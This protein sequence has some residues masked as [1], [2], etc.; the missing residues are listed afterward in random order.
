MLAMP[1]TGARATR[2][3]AVEA[4]RR[5]RFPRDHGAHPGHRTEWWYVTGWLRCDGRE[6]GVQV[7]FFRSRTGHDPANPSRFA[8]H[9]LLLAHIAIA[10][11]GH[12]RLRHAQKAARAGFADIRIATDDT[13]LRLG[14]WTLRRTPDDAYHARAHG[15]ELAIELALE[16]RLPPW[17]QGIEGYSRKGPQE[18]QASHYYSRP[19][20]QVSGSVRLGARALSI[21]DGVAWLDHE[22]SS[23]VLDP[24]AAG[25][26][27]V[28][29][30][31]DDGSAL[32]AFRIRGRDGSVLWSHARWHGQ[33]GPDARVAFEPLRTWRS[34]RSPA[35]YPIA[36][37]LTVGA[38]VLTLEPLLD[39][40]ELDA[41]ASTG[42]HYWEGAV[43]V[44]EAGRPVGRGYLE[45]TGYAEPLRI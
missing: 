19:R 42:G 40:Q 1:W 27:W 24:R 10:D 39:D 30:N 34:P 33:R 28:G 4:G 35:S 36:M 44:L 23:E 15:H 16:P 25:W 41:R 37:R 13:D 7:T 6:L 21:D 20:M 2:F 38:R 45:L 32:M 43:R 5:L 14:D 31:M 22:W 3:D 8:P 29:L 18:A 17:L 11:P 26:D 9:Q 12:G